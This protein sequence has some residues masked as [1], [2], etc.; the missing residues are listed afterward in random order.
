MFGMEL[1]GGAFVFLGFVVLYVLVVVYSTYT[2]RGSGIAQRPHNRLYT[3]APGA[4]R[5]GTL[6]S[7]RDR[8]PT[9]WSRG[10]R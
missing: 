1:A 9:N 4:G 10:C 6:G 3:G 5:R 7:D 2:Q 8:V